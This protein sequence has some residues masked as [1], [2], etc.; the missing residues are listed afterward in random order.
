[1][2]R[3]ILILSLLFCSQL[4]T[5]SNLLIEAESFDQK[6]GWVVDQQFMDLMGSPYL[7]AHGMG[8]PVEDASTTISFPRA[9]HIM[10]MYV[11][12]TGLLPGMMAKDQE[13]SL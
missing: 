4:I 2:R 7:M 11:P 5:A 3:I 12:I 13:S 9:V 6:G 8:I 10:Y 1:M